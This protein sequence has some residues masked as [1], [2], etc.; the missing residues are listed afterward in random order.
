[1]TTLVTETPAACSDLAVE[2]FEARLTYET[3]CWDVRESLQSPESDFVLIDVR[4]PTAF[5]KGHVKGSVNI[6]HREITALR[7]AEFPRGKT[8]V[9]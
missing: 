4:G 2:H 3:D 5:V 7:M 9:V 6:P 8:F 1:M